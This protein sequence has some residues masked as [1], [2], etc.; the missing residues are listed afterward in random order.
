MKEV[1][2][3]H[4]SKEYAMK[5]KY[6]LRLKVEGS[7]PS[8]NGPGGLM[9]MHWT[10]KEEL[11]QLWVFLLMEAMTPEERGMFK[12]RRF[13]RCNVIYTRYTT[14]H[15]G[16]DWDNMA[17]SFKLVGDGLNQLNV[18]EDDNPKVIENFWPKQ[19][20]GLK[21]VRGKPN[22]YIDLEIDGELEEYDD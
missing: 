13:K 19:V 12:R 2:A 18:V 11:Q 14:H 15:I 5:T 22:I 20:W 3:T 17:S 1:C 10:K 4:Y 8:L 6:V 16:L 21:R 9:R 7:P